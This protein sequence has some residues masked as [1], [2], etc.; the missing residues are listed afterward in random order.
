MLNCIDPGAATRCRVLPDEQAGGRT[1]AD[2]FL[3]AGIAGGIYVVGEDPTP[4]AIAGP[5]RLAGIGERLTAA[6]HAWRA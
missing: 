2:A 4:R 5:L 1:A 6:G 3:D